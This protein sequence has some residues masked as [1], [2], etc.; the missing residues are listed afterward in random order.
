MRTISI[1]IVSGILISAFVI[2][3]VSPQHKKNYSIEVNFSNG[4][5]DTLNVTSNSTPRLKYGSIIIERGITY[6]QIASNVNTF[7][8]LN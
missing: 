4:T 3:M 6:I 5:I 1:I 8:I 7:K 2:L